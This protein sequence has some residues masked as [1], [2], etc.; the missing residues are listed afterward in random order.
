MRK[1][2]LLDRLALGS[3]DETYRVAFW[4]EVPAE[5]RP[6]YANP[7]AVSVVKDIT[8]D[9]LGDMRAGRFIEV[10]ETLTRPQG[11]SEP[12]ARAMLEM[13]YLRRQA[14]VNEQ[15]PWDR[16]GT[17]WDGGEWFDRTVA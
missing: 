4:L 8:A 7:Q 14:D 13:S 6:F 10:V 9:E 15:N 12:E 17:H 3:I 11:I 16:Y 1:V 5:R 2:I